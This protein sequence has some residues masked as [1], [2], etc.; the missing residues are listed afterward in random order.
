MLYT[1]FMNSDIVLLWGTGVKETMEGDP[2]NTFPARA[3][4]AGSCEIGALALGKRPPGGNGPVLYVTTGYYANRLYV[5]YEDPY[6]DNLLW[7]TQKAII[8]ALGNRCDSILK[9]NPGTPSVGHFHEFIAA[10]G[11]GR[12]RVI[13]GER[14]LPELLAEAGT[15]IIDFPHTSLLQAIAMGKTILVLTRHTG[16]SEEAMVL[17]RKRAYCAG[18]LREFTGMIQAHLEG[19]PLSGNP[20]PGNTEFLERYGVHQLDGG[21][22]G[23]AVGVIDSLRQDREGAGT[24]G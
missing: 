12:I 4:A 9:L 7:E 22:A 3:V 5:S 10:R 16:L 21:V 15:V 19:K 23:R 14:P 11:Y 24:S 6:P 1:E 13:Q 17:L 2:L 20:D 8:D 18:D